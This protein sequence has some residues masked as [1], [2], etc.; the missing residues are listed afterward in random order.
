MTKD[1]FCACRLYQ[2][3]QPLGAVVEP[4]FHPFA[5]GGQ[6]LFAFLDA[7]QEAFQPPAQ[8]HVGG[9]QHGNP[10][11]ICSK[12]ERSGELILCLLLFGPDAFEDGADILRGLVCLLQDL[13]DRRPQAGVG[14]GQP[15]Q[16]GA[17]FGQPLPLGVDFIPLFRPGV[18]FGQPLQ[19]GGDRAPCRS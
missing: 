9:A 2:P 16:P 15:L 4:G 5:R 11:Q 17:G 14:F 7:E 13:F 6:R 18:D 1:I 3:V 19:F 10:L 12:A 8:I